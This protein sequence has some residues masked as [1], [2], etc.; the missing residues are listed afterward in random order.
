MCDVIKSC[1]RKDLLK[2]Q[3]ESMDFNVLKYEKFID[4]VSDSILQL[5]F[6][7]LLFVSFCYSSNKNAHNGQKRPPA[8]SFLFLLYIS[9]RMILFHMLLPKQQKINTLNSE[10]CMRINLSSTKL[11]IN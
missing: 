3:D 2:V 9:V 5:T 6:N 4:T 8:Y 7:K 11:D 1:T 10:A